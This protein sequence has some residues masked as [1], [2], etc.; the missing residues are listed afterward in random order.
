MTINHHIPTLWI[1]IFITINHHTISTNH[2]E[3]ITINHHKKRRHLANQLRRSLLLSLQLYQAS[4]QRQ[5]VL[6]STWGTSGACTLLGKTHGKTHGKMGKPYKNHRKIKVY[7]QSHGWKI[8]ELNG[9]RFLARKITDF[10]GSFSS[11]AMFD[12]RR[13]YLRSWIMKKQVSGNGAFGGDSSI[14][15]RASV[16]SWQSP[17]H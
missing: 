12:Y 13:V 5:A 1:T 2:P 14:K 6:G 16:Q 3:I 7:P 9:G 11:H 4:E 10:Y 8:R 15:N 17:R